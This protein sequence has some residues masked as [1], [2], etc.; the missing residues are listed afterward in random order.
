MDDPTPS[1]RES[2]YLILL[3]LHRETG[4]DLHDCLLMLKPV[5][6]D[7]FSNAQRIYDTKG[8]PATIAFLRSE[9]MKLPQHYISSIKMPDDGDVFPSRGVSAVMEEMS[10]YQIP[11]KK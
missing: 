9:C 10:S 1:I 8:E 3:R 2:A 7:I 11:I 6:A 4:K 5:H